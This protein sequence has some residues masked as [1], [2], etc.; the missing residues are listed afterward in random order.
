VAETFVSTVS[1]ITTGTALKTLM[2]LQTAATSRAII[3]SWWVEF[4]GTTAANAP[5]LVELVRAS[6]GITGTTVTAVKY[7]DFAPAALTT[8]KHTASVEGTPTD[9]LETHYV[10]PTSGLI[11]QYPLGREPEVPISGF[12]R[13]R[14]TAASGSV[15]AN[16]GFVWD[17]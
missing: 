6:A 16:V 9:V 3:A 11:L 12:L 8:V 15:S 10:S 7:K 14:V 1:A 4:N 17:E 13:L 2:E 5:I